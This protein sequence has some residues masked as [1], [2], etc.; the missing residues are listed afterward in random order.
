MDSVAELWNLYVALQV[1][2]F[3][4]VSNILT[5]NINNKADRRHLVSAHCIWDVLQGQKPYEQKTII[6]LFL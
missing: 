5:L 1:T 2:C 6:T 4:T 3:G